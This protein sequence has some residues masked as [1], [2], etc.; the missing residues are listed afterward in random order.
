MCD[1]FAFYIFKESPKCHFPLYSI[2]FFYMKG[3][4]NSGLCDH[5]AAVKWLGA[6]LIDYVYWSEI[7]GND[8]LVGYMV[9][10]ASGSY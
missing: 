4:D 6:C 9:L 8:M 10:G 2:F 5:I 3:Y 1:I 7:R